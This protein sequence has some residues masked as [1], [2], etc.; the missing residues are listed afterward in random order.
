MYIVISGLQ[1]LSSFAVVS[2]SAL[3]AF[4]LYVLFRFPTRY[5][6]KEVRN[7]SPLF[8]HVV[9]VIL[10][11]IFTKLLQFSNSDTEALT[12]VWASS[13]AFAFHWRVTTTSSTSS[14]SAPL[15]PSTYSH[16]IIN[17]QPP[18]LLYI[19]L[20]L[21]IFMRNNK[22]RKTFQHLRSCVVLT[23][24]PATL[25][26]MLRLER[27]TKKLD[28]LDSLF[29]FAHILMQKCK[30]FFFDFSYYSLLQYCQA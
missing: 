29:G 3:A 18:I 28:S 10:V 14:S 25:V 4:T 15:I 6:H 30:P 1:L 27:W 7:T 16:F 5:N 19:F 9:V 13:T 17:K 20:T 2:F 26:C 24:Y 23:P 12:L 21:A 11:L 8:I 22:P